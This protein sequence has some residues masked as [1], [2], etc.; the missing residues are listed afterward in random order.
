MFANV[1]IDMHRSM[2]KAYFFVDREAAFSAAMVY[3]R[4]LSVVF[5]SRELDFLV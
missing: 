5:N 2:E 1:P 3:D 4:V